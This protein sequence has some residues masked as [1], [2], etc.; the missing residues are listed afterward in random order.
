MNLN[1]NAG[2]IVVGYQGVGK[3]TLAFHNTNVIDL[4]SSNFFVDGKRDE[5]WYVP[6]CNVARSLARQGYTVCA[7][8]HEVVRKELERKP[9]NTQVIVY[10][11]LTLK[12]D[13]IR[14]LKYRYE[15]TKSE[16]DFKALKNAEQC[17]EQNITDL[18]NQTG[19]E[20]IEIT[21]MDYN[22][23]NMLVQRKAQI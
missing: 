2:Q 10:P 18:A 21:S 22:L 23:Q 9:A 6:Y 17:Y 15:Q 3:S 7:S 4:E 20:H 11:A 14:S 19:F 13:W 8:S 16:K 12:D 5:M 1:F